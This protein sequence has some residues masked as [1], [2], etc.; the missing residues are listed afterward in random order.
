MLKK[1]FKYLIN[2]LD[3]DSYILENA[4]D[5]IKFFIEF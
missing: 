2:T 1:Y 3:R 4:I 5:Q